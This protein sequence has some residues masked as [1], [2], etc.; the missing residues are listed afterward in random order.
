M[1]LTNSGGNYFTNLKKMTRLRPKYRPDGDR[2]E[3][4]HPNDLIWSE[5]TMTWSALNSTWDEIG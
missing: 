1:K 3:R 2:G 5:A 4:S